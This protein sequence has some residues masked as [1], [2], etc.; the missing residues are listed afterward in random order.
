MPYGFLPTGMTFSSL[1]VVLSITETLSD[2]LLTTYN[3]LASGSNFKDLGEVPTGIVL[4][5]GTTVLIGLWSCN[6]GLIIIIS[7]GISFKRYILSREGSEA[8][9]VLECPTP[10]IALTEP[11]VFPL[12]ISIISMTERLSNP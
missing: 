1:L 6:E 10:L 5:I 4:I 12:I 11:V 2:P 7:P 8:T 9:P 3:F